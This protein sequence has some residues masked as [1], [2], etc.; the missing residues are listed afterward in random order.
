MDIGFFKNIHSQIISLMLWL[1]AVAISKYRKIQK[2]VALL[3]KIVK[4]I[5]KIVK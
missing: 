4:Y 3:V 2:N 1:N 5:V